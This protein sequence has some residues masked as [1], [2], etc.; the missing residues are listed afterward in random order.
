M[1]GSFAAVRKGLTRT[2]ARQRIGEF[3]ILSAVFLFLVPF[4]GAHRVTDFAIF[5]IFALSFDLLYGYM[6]RLSFGHLLYLGVGAYATALSL[7]H[8]TSNPL[9]AILLGV[10]TACLVGMIIGSAAVRATG[11]CFA[12]INLAFNRVG[13]F[14]VMSPLKEITGGENGL[15][16]RNLSFWYFN[17]GSSSL[18][19]WFVLASLVVVFFLLRV[20]TSSPY[21]VLLRSIKEDERRVRF[22]GYSTYFYKWMTFVIAA[23][24]A[25]F[26]GSLTALNYAYVNPNTL[27]VHAN[28]GVIFAC[29]I[30]GP[31]RLYGAVLGGIIY[32]L[33]TN[34]LPVYF[35]RWELL[36]G[37][38]LLFIVFR[39][40]KGI[41]GSLEAFYAKVTAYES[42]SSSKE[43][44]FR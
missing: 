30:G 42:V 1:F 25:G 37:V 17:F 18:R 33:I 11:A 22:L 4:L 24:I 35:Q 43:G 34:L 14:L 27:D 8:I 21:G 6:G 26:A 39:F 12:L 29:L 13:W 10:V 19:F 38:A 23:S 5:C 20:L 16:V 15:S 31:G 28:S 41:W 9:V 44:V 32:M 3:V 36:L 2:T 40:R 7:Q